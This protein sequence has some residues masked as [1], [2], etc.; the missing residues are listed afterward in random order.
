MVLKRN[1]RDPARS[2]LRFSP[3]RIPCRSSA[4]RTRARRLREQ[5][6]AAALQ[7]P[8]AQPAEI[9]EEI[10]KAERAGIGRNRLVRAA[11]RG[12]AGL[13]NIPAESRRQAASLKI[14]AVSSQDRIRAALRQRAAVQCE[15]RRGTTL[16]PDAHS[17]PR[18]QTPSARC[19]IAGSCNQG[20]PY[21]HL[22]HND[23]HP[24][25][26]KS[27]ALSVGCA[28]ERSLLQPGEPCYARTGSP[29]IE[30]IHHRGNPRELNLDDQP[31]KYDP[32][33]SSYCP[34]RR[35]AT[36]RRKQ[37]RPATA[38]SLCQVHAYYP[39]IR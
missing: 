7:A 39:R 5:R 10:A 18:P 32:R 17:S 37:D 16:I 20:T 27:Y 19:L 2:A 13:L 35:R 22:Y 24:N 1:L 31:T 3:E 8:A 30:R 26:H 38:V 29:T 11:H 28:R 21:A 12:R 14:T 33:L 25:R 9:A 6:S 34:I 36:P 23:R 4:R 15:F